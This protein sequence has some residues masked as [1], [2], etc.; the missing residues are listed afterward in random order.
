MFP[1]YVFVALVS[2]FGIGL[3]VGICFM[4][5]CIKETV[6]YI[7]DKNSE[8]VEVIQED[9]DPDES[10]EDKLYKDPEAWKNR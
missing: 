1:E 10:M 6:G 4:R 2:G 9:N 5:A 8:G 7:I 3:F